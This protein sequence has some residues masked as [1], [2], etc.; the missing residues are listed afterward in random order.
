MCEEGDDRTKEDAYGRGLL[1][2]PIHLRGVEDIAIG[3][4]QAVYVP[5]PL[6]HAASLP[7]AVRV[8]ILASH[9]SMLN[10]A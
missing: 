4:D 1:Q 2:L 9:L 6:I 7:T 3:V 5:Q 10:L 8:L